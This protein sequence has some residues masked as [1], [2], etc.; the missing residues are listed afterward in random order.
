MPTYS[1]VPIILLAQGRQRTILNLSRVP[2]VGEYIH[3]QRPVDNGKEYTFHIVAVTH[4]AWDDDQA[5]A[6]AEVH[7]VETEGTVPDW[8]IL[9]NAD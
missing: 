8:T 5:E 2:S 3:V 1:T 6:V 4:L 9:E 7:G